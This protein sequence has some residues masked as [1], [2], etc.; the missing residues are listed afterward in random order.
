MVCYCSWF[1]SI[2]V[3]ETVSLPPEASR[4]IT[5]DITDLKDPEA[6]ITRMFD[7]WEEKEHLAVSLKNW[8]NQKVIEVLCPYLHLV[9]K[10]KYRFL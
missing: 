10:L 1:P 8:Q 5:L 3:E 9:P 6:A 7:Y 4:E 2:D